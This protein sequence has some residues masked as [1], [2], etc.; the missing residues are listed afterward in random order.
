MT[1]PTYVQLKYWFY[2]IGNTPAVNL[3]RD[4]PACQEEETIRILSLACGDARNLLFSLWCEQGHNSKRTLSFTCCDI[5]PAVLARN[6]VLFTLIAKGRTSTELWD[7]FYHFY[8]PAETL[9]VLRTHAAGLVEASDSI[10]KWESSPYGKLIQYVNKATLQELRRYWT[11]YASAEE[12]P[13]ARTAIAKRS[14]EIGGM[15]FS[16]GIRSAGPLWCNAIETTGVLYREF[17]KTG[18]VAGNSDDLLR[19]KGKGEVNPMFAVSSAAS[20]DFAVHYGAE[21]LLGFHLPEAFQEKAS[22]QKG[23]VVQQSKRAVMI[24]K[25]QF[26]AW[27][28]SFAHYSSK[29]RVQISFFCGEALAL[30]YDLQLAIT[31]DQR[32]SQF[33]RTYVKPWSGQP[34]LLDGHAELTTPFDVIDTS[35]LGDHVGFINILSAT[36]PLLQRN[37]SSVLYTESLLMTSKNVSTS[38]S[39]ALGSDVATFSLLIGLAPSGIITGVTLDAVSNETALFNFVQGDTRGQKQYRMRVSWKYPQFSDANV[40][41]VLATSTRSD[42][43]VRFEAKELA[44]YLFDIYKTM[45]ANEDLSKLTAQMTDIHSGHP[46]FKLQ[47]YTRAGMVAL[48]RLVRATVQVNWEQ[49][50]QIFSNHLE[51]DR[52]LIVGSNSFQEFYVHLHNLGVWTNSS[53]KSSPNQLRGGLGLSLRQT[54][55]EEGILAGDNSPPVVHLV[56]VVPRAK[57]TVFTGK[58]PDQIGTPALHISVAQ[59]KG[60]EQYENLFHSFHAFFG[61]VIYDDKTHNISIVEEDENGWLGSADLVVTCAVPAFGLLLGPRDGIRV[62]LRINTNPDSI[63][64][65]AHLGMRMEIFETGFEQ[66]K[67]LFVC[68]DAPKLDT[69][70]SCSTQKEWMERYPTQK[71]S[72]VHTLVTLNAD[73]KATHLQ[74]HM[75]FQKDSAESKALSTGAVVTVIEHS[76]NTMILAIGSSLKRKIVFPFPIQGS[77]SKTRIA[78]KSSWIEIAVPIMT[79]LDGDRFNSWTQMIVE[80]GRPPL[81][82]SIPRVNLES[83]PLVTFDK[84][85]DSSWL[86]TFMGT[87]F[88]DT[89]R[90]LSRL[91]QATTTT[92]TT[93]TRHDLK[94]S[95]GTM[96]FSF[97]G[98]NEN[99]IGP[100]KTFQ[101]ALETTGAHTLIFATALRFDLDLGSVVM[102]AYVV[103]LTIPRVKELLQP[104][105]ALQGTQPRSIRVSDDE[106]ILWK[107]MLP[108]LAER[109]RT[110]NHKSTCEYQTK[111]A[112]LSTEEGTSPLCSCGEGM[113]SR[114]ELAKLGLKE[115]APF[116]KYAIRVAIAPIF[117]VPYVE[118]A[119]SDLLQG[120]SREAPPPPQSQGPSTSIGEGSSVPSPTGQT[121]RPV[122]PKC[123][124]C[125]N[126][127]A[128]DKL[129]LCGG[130]RKARYCG[131]ECQKAHRK[132]HR[133]DCVA[134]VKG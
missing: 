101:L 25:S 95:L 42:I 132:V 56:L 112:P 93:N 15:I 114:T 28:E 46:M 106:S 60:R 33:A 70:Q 129:L 67:R 134:S 104:L 99:H 88:S 31:L 17:W 44:V 98:I 82:W 85:L 47:R 35:N 68:R 59:T 34:L 30:S 126:G 120:P 89:E 39:T 37:A 58:T 20:K 27:C 3:L 96:F 14:K 8:V 54:S 4:I 52:S 130:C 124:Y 81:C 133:R 21:P 110:W 76:P 107:R 29:G 73:H 69:L 40:V 49:T 51:T 105:H 32:S 16:T 100:C 118:L 2:P 48:L 121:S 11:R 19:L 86:P 97:A 13:Q 53:L 66:R 26:K 109:C 84:N 63:M 77:L 75:D 111:G 55:I 64:R 10:E 62:A 115:W 43:Q 50:M 12:F 74:S 91:N 123:D 78:R 5:E 116:A 18:V 6:I 125:G 90:S 1:S 65:F 131:S 72:S 117:P 128:R 103:P 23:S 41:G 36:V 38:L 87:T 7:L 94:Q 61:N 80:S 57:L 22:K 122:V 45:F 119:M 24:A 108:A 83:Q 79:A 127:K 71:Q 113:I 102:E 9:F 92:T